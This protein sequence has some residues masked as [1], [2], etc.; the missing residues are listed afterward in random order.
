VTVVIGLIIAALIIG[1]LFKVGRGT[2]ETT[3]HLLN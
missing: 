1:A 3:S 2:P